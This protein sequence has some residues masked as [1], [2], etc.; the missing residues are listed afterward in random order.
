MTSGFSLRAPVRFRRFASFTMWCQHCRQDVPAISQGETARCVRCGR[1]TAGPTSAAASSAGVA[2]SSQWGLDLGTTVDQPDSPTI[3]PPAVEDDDW[4]LD[5]KLRLLQRK[6][7]IA[8]SAGSVENDPRHSTFGTAAEHASFPLAASDTRHRGSGDTKSTSG[9]D[10]GSRSSKTTEKRRPAIL[11]WAIMSLGLMSFVCGGVLL[12]WSFLGHRNDLWGLGMPITLVGQFGLLL[13]LVLQLD[14]LWQA[15]RHTADTLNAV[16]DRLSEINHATTLLRATHSS[17][18]QSFYT[19][20]A[21][22]A[23]PHLLL[24]DLKGQ[25]DLLSTKMSQQR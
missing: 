25:L 8:H 21:E 16:D 10:V 2:E 19:H 3:A 11:A 24:A 9:A 20:L 12:A 13:G 14:H 15:S 4:L 1:A 18:A 23:H 22:G 5:H 6:L 17:P 7:N